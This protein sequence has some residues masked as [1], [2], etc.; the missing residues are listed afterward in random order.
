VG[1]SPIAHAAWTLGLWSSAA[2]FAANWFTNHGLIPNGHLKNEEKVLT[3]AQADAVKARYT[4][5]VEGG[6]MF[7][8][9]KDWTLTTGGAPA[10]D[11]RFLEQQE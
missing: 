2:E 5:A 1:L 10:A 8:T 7:V 3:E 4:V 9:G 11:M 6:D